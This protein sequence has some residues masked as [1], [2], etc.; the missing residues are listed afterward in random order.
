ML[1]YGTANFTVSFE[2]QVPRNYT[3]VTYHMA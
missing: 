3:T 1:I 2:W